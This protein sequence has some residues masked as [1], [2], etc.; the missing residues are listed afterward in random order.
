MDFVLVAFTVV[1]GLRALVWLLGADR[2]VVADWI[3]D[4]ERR[5]AEPPPPPQPAPPTGPP[6]P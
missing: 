6:G 5:G 3:A 4:E 2:N 1:F